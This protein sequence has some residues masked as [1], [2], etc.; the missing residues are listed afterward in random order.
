MW[1]HPVK[2]LRDKGPVCAAIAPVK[3]T[4]LWNLYSNLFNTFFERW[5]K[6]QAE[7]VE[8]QEEEEEKTWRLLDNGNRKKGNPALSFVC[9]FLGRARGGS[10]VLLR[11]K[12]NFGWEGGTKCGKTAIMKPDK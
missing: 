9:T 8:E 6:D 1:Q 3:P 11:G 4:R 10:D 2:E 5:K 7:D 12:K